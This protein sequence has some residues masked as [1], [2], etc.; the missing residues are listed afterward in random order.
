MRWTSWVIALAACGGPDEHVDRIDAGDGPDGSDI[1]IPAGGDFT[2]ADDAG[3]DATPE[4][5]GLSIAAG[6]SATIAGCLT[7]G[8]VDGFELA[9][10]APAWLSAVLGGAGDGDLLVVTDDG[11]DPVGADEVAGGVAVTVPGRVPAGT[12]RVRVREQ[13]GDDAGD[14]TITVDALVCAAAAAADFTEAADGAGRDNDMLAL[15]TTPAP[16]FAATATED[17]APEAS[18]LT[19]G[20][21]DVLG[22]DGVSAPLDADGD[23]YH[24]RDSFE[25]EVAAGVR[26]A[27]VLIDWAD[28]DDEIDLDGALLPA[29]AVEPVGLGVSIARPE[30]FG[31]AFD[32]DGAHWLWIGR[33]VGI[34]AADADV[35]YRATVCG[36][37]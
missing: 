19:L 6:G 28:P 34:V 37:E 9:L 4:A 2:E 22:V 14:Y 24:D 11:D 33:S 10:D 25:L 5:T 29:G 26:R 31:A 12:Y 8:D 21:G 32:D 1:C 30:G 35:D 16:E 23:A 20:D 36:F 7:A 17:D 13:G 15:T 3:N 18:G 27:V